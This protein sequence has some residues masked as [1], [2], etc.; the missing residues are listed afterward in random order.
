MDKNEG[1]AERYLDQA[2]PQFKEAV[3]GWLLASIYAKL[4]AASPADNG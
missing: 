2:D 1:I 3:F 4:R